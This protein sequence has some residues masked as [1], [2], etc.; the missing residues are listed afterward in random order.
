VDASLSSLVAELYAAIHLLAGYAPPTVPPDVHRVPQ[1]QIRE[2][3]C[4]GQPC[5]IKAVYDSTLGVFIDEKLDVQHN[6]F[7]RSILLHELVHHVQ[8]TSGRFDL[9][10]SQCVRRNA[11]EREAYYIQNRYLMEMND[12]HRVSM[13]GW[14]ARCD[15]A[16]VPTPKK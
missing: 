6:V 3:F 9:G 1:A 2:Q 8:A 7:E 13:T 15:D 10:N 5:E 11:A 12:G 16:E 4:K 14:A